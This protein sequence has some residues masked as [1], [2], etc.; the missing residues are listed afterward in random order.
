MVREVLSNSDFKVENSS[1]D[2]GVLDLRA[3]DLI[4]FSFIE[5]Q[6][7][8]D[9]G[10]AW[11]REGF[12]IVLTPDLLVLLQPWMGNS[13][14]RVLIGA[15]SIKVIKAFYF[16]LLVVNITFWLVKNASKLATTFIRYFLI[17]FISQIVI[18]QS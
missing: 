10:D 1:L 18:Y 7:I 8:R 11:V 16:L 17:K 4:L 15:N 6:E 13:G 14:V 12:I 3:I 2:E 9:I 5:G